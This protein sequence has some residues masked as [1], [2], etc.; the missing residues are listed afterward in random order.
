MCLDFQVDHH[1]AHLIG[2]LRDHTY[3]M[4]DLFTYFML[5]KKIVIG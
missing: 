1:L 4:L 2:R 3:F 5:M